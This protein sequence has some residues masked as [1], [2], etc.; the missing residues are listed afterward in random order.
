[1]KV[2]LHVTK[3]KVKLIT[4]KIKLYVGTVTLKR[5]RNEKMSE[6]VSVNDEK[7]HRTFMVGPC[8][9]GKTYL[10]KKIL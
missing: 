5:K 1:M 9:S 4:K 10:L 6:K 8:F 3:S 2:V 7:N